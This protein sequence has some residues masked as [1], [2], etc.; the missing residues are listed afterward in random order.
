[1]TNCSSPKTASHEQV[2]AKLRSLETLVIG[3]LAGSFRNKFYSLHK[4]LKQSQLAPAWLY[5]SACMYVVHNLML[6]FH[7]A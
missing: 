2:A 4:A 3:G 6:L 7:L 1:M 5:H